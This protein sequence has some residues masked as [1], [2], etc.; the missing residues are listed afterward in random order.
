MTSHSVFPVTRNFPPLIWTLVNYAHYILYKVSH[1]SLVQCDRIETGCRQS[2]FTIAL[3]KWLDRVYK[4]IL[5]IWL[6]M[7]QYHKMTHKDVIEIEVSIYW[8]NNPSISQSINLSINL[9]IYELT[10]VQIMNQSTTGPCSSSSNA[11][12]G[13]IHNHARSLGRHNALRVPSS[14]PR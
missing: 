9:L 11:S 14:S 5:Y 12:S 2:Y 7:L 1:L 13:T 8:S 6:T 4:V 3:H 10:N